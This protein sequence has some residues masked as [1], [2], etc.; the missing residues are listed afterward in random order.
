MFSCAFCEIFKNI[1]STEHL[2]TTTLLLHIHTI[3][4]KLYFFRKTFPFLTKLFQTSFTGI[5]NKSIWIVEIWNVHF[6]WTFECFAW[7]SKKAFQNFCYDHMFD[8]CESRTGVRRKMSILN[9]FK[10]KKTPFECLERIDKNNETSSILQLTSKEVECVVTELNSV[11]KGEW[12]CK[13]KT[14]VCFWE[15]NA[16]FHYISSSKWL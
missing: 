9:Y 14:K 7:C 12:S 1:F 16:S 15:M 2:Q 3:S 11:E 8:H 13:L 6:L 10:S 4:W 5:L